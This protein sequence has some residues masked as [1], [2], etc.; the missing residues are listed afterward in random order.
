METLDKWPATIILAAARV[1]ARERP[2][3]ADP[4]RSR[5]LGLR[6][7]G[8]AGGRRAVSASEDR[9]L[10]VW[11]LESGRELLTLKGHAGWV[12]A[13]AVTPDGRRAVSGCADGTLKVWELESGR[14]LR[15]LQGHARWVYAV[16][17][18]P[19]RRRRTVAAPS[20]DPR[21][22]LSRSGTSR[23]AR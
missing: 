19:W 6:R 18:T 23:A 15:T 14:E 2:G 13:V 16:A 11:E 20:P 12:Q 1:G 8:D 4:Q 5:P 9:T 17:V 22:I 7:G 21:T 3:A 10:R